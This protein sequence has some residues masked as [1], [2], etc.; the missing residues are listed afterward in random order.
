MAIPPETV[1]KGIVES[2]FKKAPYDYL[3]VVLN[4]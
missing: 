1:E 4:Q 2:Y 3:L